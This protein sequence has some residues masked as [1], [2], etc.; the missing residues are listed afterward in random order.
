MISNNKKTSRALCTFEETPRTSLSQSSPG[1]D[2]ARL[3]AASGLEV[4]PLPPWSTVS[5]AGDTILLALLH[6]AA[7]MAENV[8]APPGAQPFRARAAA[9]AKAD[10]LGSSPPRLSPSSRGERG[11]DEGTRRYFS[12][13]RAKRRLLGRLRL[14][15]LPMPLLLL[16]SGFGS[17]DPL[18]SSCSCCTKELIKLWPRLATTRCF[19]S[20]DGLFSPVVSVCR[21]VPRPASVNT[22]DAISDGVKCVTQGPPG[23]FEFRLV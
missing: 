19:S 12:E 13:L 4:A 6:A 5:P 8:G 20:E 14:L 3:R 21:G 2:A 18:S 10:C 15:P 9:G 11:G 16:R 17:V 23:L 7:T 1:G 22:G